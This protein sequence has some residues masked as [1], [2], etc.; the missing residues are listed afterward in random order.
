MKVFQRKRKAPE[1]NENDDP[2]GFPAKKQKADIIYKDLDDEA[3][4]PLHFKNAELLPTTLKD[5]VLILGP[6]SHG[7]DALVF[8]ISNQQ[9]ADDVHYSCV[10]RFTCFWKL[11][12]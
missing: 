1:P 8:T 5:D 2:A 7:W 6:P 3:T 9:T 4:L 10:W 12:G 11:E